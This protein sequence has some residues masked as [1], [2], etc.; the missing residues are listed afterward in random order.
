MKQPVMQGLLFDLSEIP[1]VEVQRPVPHNRLKCYPEI[2]V[3]EVQRVISPPRLP[4]LVPMLDGRVVVAPRMWKDAALQVEGLDV[5]RVLTWLS[6]EEAQEQGEALEPLRALVQDQAEGDI[7]EV[8]ELLCT[9]LES[10]ETEDQ[11]VVRVILRALIQER[12]QEEDEDMKKQTL[13][14]DPRTLEEVQFAI[15]ALFEERRTIYSD[16]ARSGAGLDQA[17][18]ARLFAIQQEITNLETLRNRKRAAKRGKGQA[19]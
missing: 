7:E 2:P 5:K 18:R 15:D 14:T 3:V 13:D 1:A 4:P 17:T 12:E 11:T 6:S 8:K 10:D 9:W 19:A 16:L